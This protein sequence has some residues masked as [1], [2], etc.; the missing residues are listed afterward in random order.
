MR[1]LALLLVLTAA[2][3]RGAPARLGIDIGAAAVV[4]SAFDA[5]CKAHG[6]VYA[7]AEEERTRRATYETNRGVVEKHNSAFKDGRV[8]WAMTLDGPFADLTDAEFVDRHLM[9]PQNCS[10][11][12]NASAGTTERGELPRAVDWRTKGV[13]T[14]VKNQG[15]CGSCWTFSTTG[16]LEAHHCIKHKRDCSGWTGLS[17][18]NLV[19]CAGAYDN[20]GCAGG[21]PSHAFEY[22]R[23]N[24]GIDTEDAYA[25]VGKDE[26]CSFNPADVGATVADVFN[27][28]AY[29]EQGIADALAKVGPVA[30]AYQV[31]GDFRLYSHGIYDS[32]NATTGEVMCKSGPMDVN[33]AVMA[34]GYGEADVPGG[35]TGY[36]IVKNSWGS[37][38]GME[39]YFWIKRG[40]NLCGLA[41]CAS[42]PIV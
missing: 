18:Q 38:W 35:S 20:H 32:R 1:C 17:E 6:R 26:K 15:H 13:I 31:S 19:D 4:P 21:L 34:V 11:T 22:V 14:P 12:K 23:Y 8:T 39:G 2:Q 16:T 37:L 42:Y 10:A 29:D 5:W 28:T 3:A 7:T 33:H 24:G 41:D 25:Y 40:E 9:A 30:I 36:F 27:I